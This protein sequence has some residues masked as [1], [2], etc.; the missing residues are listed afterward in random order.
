MYRAAGDLLSLTREFP[1]SF[2]RNFAKPG[3]AWTEKLLQ[4]LGTVGNLE[5]CIIHNL[6]NNLHNLAQDDCLFVFTPG[7]EASQ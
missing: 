1:D 6:H 7:P 5:L 2:L 4:I 3:S